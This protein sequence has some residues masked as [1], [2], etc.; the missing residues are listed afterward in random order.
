MPLV[1]TDYTS[2]R[3]VDLLDGVLALTSTVPDGVTVFVVV[4][5]TFGVVSTVPFFGELLPSSCEGSLLVFLVS[6]VP[7]VTTAPPVPLSSWVFPASCVGSVTG[8][9]VLA[10]T[11]PAVVTASSVPLSAGALSPDLLPVILYLFPVATTLRNRRK[12]RFRISPAFQ[13]KSRPSLSYC[14]VSY[15]CLTDTH[16]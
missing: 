5:P 6:T 9:V 10:S 3:R 4:D 11:V 16:V 12:N 14:G 1:G 7:V 15:H 8:A 2:S 13:T